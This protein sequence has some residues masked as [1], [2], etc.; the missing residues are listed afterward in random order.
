MIKLIG[1]TQ[2]LATYPRDSSIS[3][4]TGTYQIIRVHARIL[5]EVVY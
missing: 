2:Y 3:V 4:F 1:M 5:R